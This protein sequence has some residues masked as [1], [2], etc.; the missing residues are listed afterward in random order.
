MFEANKT[1]MWDGWCLDGVEAHVQILVSLLPRFVLLSELVNLSVPHL[2][3]GG[4]VGVG[5][6]GGADHL[7]APDQCQLKCSS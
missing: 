7:V 5:W 3:T 1:G 2:Q 6:G 4:G